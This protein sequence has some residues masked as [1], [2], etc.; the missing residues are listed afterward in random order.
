LLSGSVP[1]L[2]NPRHERFAQE[3]A[4]GKSQSDAY[5]AAGF[6]GAAP[7]LEAGA[8]RLIRND[9]IRARVAEIVGM[10]AERAV[11]T[12][13]SLIYEAHDI[14][15]KALAAGQYAA[16]T[17]ALTAKAK[18]AGE[19]VEKSEVKGEIEVTDARERLAHKLAGFASARDAERG[20]AKPH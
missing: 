13:E 10:A 2:S 8:S 9:K 4:K 17:G 20:A 15:T 12:R 19:W 3:L 14:Q 6:A 1:A 7:T 16:A 18:L 5:G 11:V